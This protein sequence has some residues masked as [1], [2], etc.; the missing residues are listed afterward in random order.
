[1][2]RSPTDA[3][4]LPAEKPRR[5][6][7]LRQRRSRETRA[8]LVEAAMLLWSERGFDETRVSDICER[9][10][11]SAALFYF[12]FPRKED[13][14]V[15]R[16]LGTGTRT[17]EEWQSLAPTDISTRDA[18]HALLVGATRRSART[19]KP[20]LARTVTEMLS[21]SEVW[22]VVR[23]G[24][25]GDMPTTFAAVFRRGQER[26]EVDESLD[27]L[28]LANMLTHVFL[29]ALLEWARLDGAD[30]QTLVWRRA[31]VLLRGANPRSR[32]PG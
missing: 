20:L 2:T 10:G 3:R 21:N 19:P 12:Y 5:Q 4:A 28:D 25:H 29:M 16:A 14:L 31:E 18:I 22:P 11:V 8:R 26:G 9:A 32:P 30:V 6:S 15:E 17:W 24:E 1:M 23:Q 27:P 13:V 7:S